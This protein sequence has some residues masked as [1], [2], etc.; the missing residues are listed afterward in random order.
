VRHN[1]AM[2][3][4]QSINPQVAFASMFAFGALLAIIAGQYGRNPYF[5][6]AAAA[7]ALAT[8]VTCPPYWAVALVGK[9]TGKQPDKTE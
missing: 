4:L 9:I 6:V 5:T 7:L 8:Y 1:I 3:F 2:K